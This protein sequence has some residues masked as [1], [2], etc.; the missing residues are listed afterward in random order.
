MRQI[1]VCT[2]VAKSKL[3]HSHS[4]NIVTIAQDDYIRCDQ[5][6]VF[7]EERQAAQFLF[8]LV[9]EFVTWSVNPTAVDRGRLTSGDLPKLGE[10]AEVIETDVIAGLRRPAKS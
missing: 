3:E 10:A 6:E 9:E 8:E 2:G 5:T 7:G 1:G 4:W